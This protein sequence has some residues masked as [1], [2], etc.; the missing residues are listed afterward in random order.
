MIVQCTLYY[1][2]LNLKECILTDKLLPAPLRK[3][4]SS[5]YSSS[6]FGSLSFEPFDNNSCCC[7]CK[8][9]NSNASNCSNNVCGKKGGRISHPSPR[10]THTTHYTLLLLLQR[11]HTL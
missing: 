3:G 9:T 10:G 5:S 1:M 7:G 4:A 6:S 8:S 2:Y 11:A